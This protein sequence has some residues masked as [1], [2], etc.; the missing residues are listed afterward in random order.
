MRTSTEIDKISESLALAALKFKPI[1]KNKINPHFKTKYA[2]L[3]S[4]ID[5]TRD[6][7]A[8]QG[9]FVIQSSYIDNGRLILI[10]KLLHKS[11][12]WLENDISLK[13]AQDTPQG[14]GSILTY[15]RRYG[16]CAILNVVGDEDDDG[17]MAQPNNAVKDNNK[18]QSY[19]EMIVANFEK[20]GITLQQLEHYRQRPMSNWNKSDLDA[21]ILLGTQFR[22]KKKDP[23]TFIEDL[24]VMHL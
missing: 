13:I 2:D 3:S 17:N 16:L 10:T 5:G 23:Q 24:S 19:P 1:E 15:S 12:Q 4:V 14:L 11:G 9:I 20:Y 22:D 7:L 6:A 8:E 18:S 21:L